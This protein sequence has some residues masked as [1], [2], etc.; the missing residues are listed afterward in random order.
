MQFS[1]LSTLEI[2]LLAVGACV[3][4]WVSGHG[5][6]RWVVRLDSDRP[7]A[8]A[9]ELTAAVLLAGFLL[10][11]ILGECQRVP[12]VLP[13]P[14]W[15]W[16]R[17]IFHGLLLIL[18]LAATWIDL[19][20]Y[21][22]PDEITMAGMLLGIVLATFSGDLQLIHLWIDWNPVAE[23]LHGGDAVIPEWIRAHR[24]WHGLAW[25][26]AGLACGGGLT[27]L[28]RY[29]SGLVLGRE[30]LGLG[31]V[32]LMAM[33]GSF[34]GW[35]AVLFIF[36][37]APFCGLLVGLVARAIANRPYVPYGPFLS[38]AT[39]V[40][41]FGW[42]WIWLFPTGDQPGRWAVRNLFG[43]GVSLAILGGTAL[44]ALCLLLG[45]VRLYGRIP[46]SGRGRNENVQVTTP[47]DTTPVLNDDSDSQQ[48]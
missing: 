19:R 21:E 33:I 37:L 28:V 18:L 42:R 32:T 4:G 31:D 45:L 47:V 7:P 8:G 2:V 15:R 44:G 22:I 29:V 35:Q 27:W 16:G 20:H 23:P 6:S 9:L 1:N 24:H 3:A 38:A 39:V 11:M 14:Q 13:D 36:L 40:V 5:V 48:T 10:A 43:D 26:T 34:V 17:I 25:S 46:V 41:L 12:L 30:A